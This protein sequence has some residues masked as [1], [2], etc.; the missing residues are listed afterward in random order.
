MSAAPDLGTI[1]AIVSNL[2]QGL[3]A[4]LPPET[5]LKQFLPAISLPQTRF[6][7][8]YRLSDNKAVL[9]AASDEERPT[10]TYIPVS[11]PIYAQALQSLS[12]AQDSNSGLWVAPL[13]STGTTFGFLEV[14]LQDT[15][16]PELD[17]AL[18]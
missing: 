9:Q 14:G 4:K 2:D 11:T 5:L 8:V 10:G 12:S 16:A 7:R 15:A 1:L 6:V 3:Q 17:S 18:Q 13:H